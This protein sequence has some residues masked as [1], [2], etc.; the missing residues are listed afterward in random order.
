MWDGLDAMYLSLLDLFHHSEKIRSFKV[1][2]APAIVT[3]LGD[4]PTAELR[5]AADE[6]LQ[7]TSLIG[8]TFGFGFAGIL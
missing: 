3:K 5:S 1:L 6:M 4:F 2:A 8:Y 7:Q